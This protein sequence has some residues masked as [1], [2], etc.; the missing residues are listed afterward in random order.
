M[1]AGETIT[2]IQKIFTHIVNHLI[3]LG[4]T[5][6]I[7]ELNIKILKCFDR[8][9]Q[10]KVTAILESRDLTTL[11]STALFGKLREHQLEMNRLKEQENGD[12]KARGIALKTVALGDVRDTESRE[13]SEI[14]TL[15]IVTRKF[16]KFLKKKGKEKN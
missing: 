8:T 15:N 10:P 5:F 6:D 14:E 3:V 4:K 9:L 2:D 12:K 16:S 11:S 7:D 13:G 1:Q